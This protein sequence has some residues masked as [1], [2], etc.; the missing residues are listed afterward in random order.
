MAQ[1]EFIDNIE[2]TVQCVVPGRG[3]NDFSMALYLDSLIFVM[4]RILSCSKRRL[5]TLV[6]RRGYDRSG[7]F[8]LS[9]ETQV[10]EYSL[11]A[12]GGLRTMRLSNSLHIYAE[13]ARLWLVRPHVVCRDGSGFQ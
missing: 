6:G 3:P 4:T 11:K 5:R 10:P 7:T 13:N 9:V 8:A 2:N 12:H 1:Y